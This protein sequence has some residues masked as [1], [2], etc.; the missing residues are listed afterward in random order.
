[1][2][3]VT[4]GYMVNTYS[5]RDRLKDLNTKAYYLLVALSFV[6]RTNPRI[7]LKWAFTLTAL[8]A[9][10]PVQ[11]YIKSERL[12]EI[13]RALKVVCLMAALFFTLWWVWHA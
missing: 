4:D 6:Y 2:E 13:V 1:M 10:L 9:V 7:S 11:D 8:V 3:A 5:I 12:L